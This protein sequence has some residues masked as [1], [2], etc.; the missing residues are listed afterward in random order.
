MSREALCEQAEPH[1]RGEWK[2]G[3]A[4]LDCLGVEVA[5]VVDQLECCVE[6]AS[7][8][9]GRCDHVAL[10]D[11]SHGIGR[12]AERELNGTEVRYAN[13]QADFAAGVLY[14]V[15]EVLYEKCVSFL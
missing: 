5:G 1:G 9:V 3:Q 7:L 8:E 6:D 11:Q 13:R 15:P 2:S 14:L 12:K 10:E 4:E